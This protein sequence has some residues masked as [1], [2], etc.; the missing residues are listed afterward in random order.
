M[1]TTDWVSPFGW[2]KLIR[3]PESSWAYFFSLFLYHWPEPQLI[4]IV[5]N[6]E[7]G[8]I[9]AHEGSHLIIIFSS[10][11][12]LDSLVILRSLSFVFSYVILSLWAHHQMAAAAVSPKKMTR[13]KNEASSDEGLQVYLFFIKKNK[14]IRRNG[15]GI[16]CTVFSYFNK[17]REWALSFYI[18]YLWCPFDLSFIKG[19]ESAIPAA[20]EL[21]SFFLLGI[22]G[23]HIVP[24]N[25]P[26][27]TKR[28]NE[29]SF[30]C[31][32]AS[33]ISICLTAHLL[34]DF[35]MIA[36]SLLGS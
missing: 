3:W 20:H 28:K 4:F 6:G 35:M 31:R 9:S 29:S 22:D 8:K 2:L 13:E 27:F 18:F 21:S 14:G 30:M 11:F 19:K 32:E 12:L 10:P 15:S 26:S 23:H 5:A 25:G 1:L 17:E 36:A 34:F 7:K 24:F 16:S 33:T